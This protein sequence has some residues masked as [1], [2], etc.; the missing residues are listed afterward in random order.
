MQ[1]LIGLL[2]GKISRL[3]NSGNWAMQTGSLFWPIRPQFAAEN[4][5]VQ[6]TKSSL[7]CMEESHHH[8]DFA[9]VVSLCEPRGG[10]CPAAQSLQCH[11]F[12]QSGHIFETFSSN[13]FFRRLCFIGGVMKS[14]SSFVGISMDFPLSGVTRCTPLLRALSV[15]SSNFR[16]NDSAGELSALEV[17]VIPQTLIVTGA[18]KHPL[19]KDV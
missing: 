15:V 8:P 7:L 6:T 3:G 19:F 11:S 9:K 17:H 13:S 14:Y 18:E 5:E 16:N 12:L 4:L 1:H 10:L 2:L